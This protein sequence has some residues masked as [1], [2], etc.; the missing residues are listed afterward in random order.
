MTPLADLQRDYIIHYGQERQYLDLE[1][2]ELFVRAETATWECSARD[3]FD[4]LR[5]FHTEYPSVTG[6]AITVDVTHTRERLKLE[7]ATADS[8]W[9]LV[10]S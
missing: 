5:K 8:S 9:K 10:E 7:R 3:V 6:T 2:R 1:T 4:A